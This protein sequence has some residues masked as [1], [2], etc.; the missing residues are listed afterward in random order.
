MSHLIIDYPEYIDNKIQ[1]SDEV[2][3]Q[4]IQEHTGDARG[5]WQ[6][7]RTQQAAKRYGETQ[8]VID[9]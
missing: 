3:E 7:R 4:V 1:G 2:K 5:I 8:A 6:R 9:P